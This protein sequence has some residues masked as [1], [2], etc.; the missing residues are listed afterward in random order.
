LGGRRRH[1]PRSSNLAGEK[2]TWLA[3]DPRFGLFFHG[4]AR[5]GISPCSAV[6]GREAPRIEVN[7][8]IPLPRRRFTVDDYYRIA[9]AGV[10]GEDDRVELIEGEIIEM[11]PIGSRHAACVNR[12]NGIFSVGVGARAI[13][14]VQNPVRLSD[15]SEPQPDLA[16]LE[17]RADAYASGHPR[18]HDVL[19]LIE[20]ADSS[21]PVDRHVKAPLYAVSGIRELWIVD[22]EAGRIHVFREPASDGYRSTRTVGRGDTVQ[23]LAFPELAIEAGDV[24]G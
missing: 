22:I 2:S 19:L 8:T 6:Q 7:M 5:W 17:P 10:L 18:A 16:V 24:L 13:V 23:P 12:L 14:A 9:A 15:L 21:L 11:S 4:S 3:R 20:V 1:G